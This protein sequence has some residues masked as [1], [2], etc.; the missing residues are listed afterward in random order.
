MI[1]Y[2]ATANPTGPAA[3]F[4]RRL[5]AGQFFL[6]VSDEILDEARD[7]LS[8][9]R[10]RAKNPRV[11]DETVRETLDLLDRMARM[12]SDV[13]SLFS[14][15]RDPD[16]EPYLNLAITADADD[17]VTRDKDLLDLMQDAGF[18]A[19]YPRLTILNPV[20]PLQILTRPPQQPS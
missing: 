13:P 8:R 14:L 6:Y 16:D 1:L 2:Q 9:P 7:V 3:E 15:P 17:L 20:A 10:I 11:T 5:Q 19:Q 4:L 18:C 12:L